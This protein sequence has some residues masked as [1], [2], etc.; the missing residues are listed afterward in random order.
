MKLPLYWLNDY[1]DISDISIAELQA[2]LFS[3]GFEVEE[4]IEK[5]KD[6]SGVVVG[7]VLTCEAIPETH[8]HLC[9]SGRLWRTRNI[10]NLLWC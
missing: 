6:I 4:V 10:P 7:E 9:M 5:G 1:V 2:K 8:L 3:C